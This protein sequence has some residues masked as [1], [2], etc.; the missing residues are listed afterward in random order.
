MAKSPFES[1]IAAGARG[2]QNATHPGRCTMP[3][4]GLH[5]MTRIA[6]VLPVAFAFLVACAGTPPPREALDAAE[7][8]IE[9]ARRLGAQD[10]APVELERAT[11]RMTAA[12][13][14]FAGR[15]YAMAQQYAAQAELEAQLAQY[16]SRAATGRE[17]V[18]RRIDENARLR[19][20]LLGAGGV[21]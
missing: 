15:D 10:Y 21:Q 9:D 11:Q 3:L 18:R 17:E 16:R 2:R 7:L 13:A 19:R 1:A 12:D 14:A 5:D 4:F 6:F 8:A 20:E